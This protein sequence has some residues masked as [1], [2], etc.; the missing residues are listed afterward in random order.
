[1]TMTLNRDTKSQA[2][3]LYTEALTLSHQA[4]AEGLRRQLRNFA[5]TILDTYAIGTDEARVCYT[6]SQVQAYNRQQAERGPEDADVRVLFN[7]SNFAGYDKTLDVYVV[8]A[9][10][11]WTAAKVGA[12]FTRV[13]D[14]GH[15]HDCC[16]CIHATTATA[17]AYDLD[18][19]H[20]E[21]AEWIVVVTVFRNV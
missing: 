14:C 21:K 13:H 6:E 19:A 15:E 17:M 11:G 1:M 18:N 12:A 16:G 4:Q 10:R 20:G 3:R 5:R 2:A 7:L 8:E 9:P